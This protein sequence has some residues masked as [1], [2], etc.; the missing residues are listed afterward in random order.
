MLQFPEQTKREIAELCAVGTAACVAFETGSAMRWC[1][2]TVLVLRI[3]DRFTK[4]QRHY[5]AV[6]LGLAASLGAITWK[7]YDDGHVLAGTIT[8]VAILAEIARV[9][10]LQKKNPTC[11]KTTVPLQASKWWQGFLAGTLV[12][13]AITTLVLMGLDMLYEMKS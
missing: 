8:Q 5:P 13:A 12:F 3:M 11:E 1:L 7:G 2:G 10:Y 9:A 6:Y 4:P